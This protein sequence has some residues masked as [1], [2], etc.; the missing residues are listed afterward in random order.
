MFK[1]EHCFFV[2]LVELFVLLFFV[3]VYTCLLALCV[4]TDLSFYDISVVICQ[5]ITKSLCDPCE[6]VRR[7]TFYPTL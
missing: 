4:F 5:N 3:S 1:F 6:V 2:N 7:Q